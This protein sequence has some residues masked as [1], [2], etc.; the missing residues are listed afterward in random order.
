LKPLFAVPFQDTKTWQK[1]MGL[2]DHPHFQVTN[3]DVFGM[4]VIRRRLQVFEVGACLLY[5]SSE[6]MLDDF[7]KHFLPE[8]PLQ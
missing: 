3:E 7:N 8:E 5:N 4:R 6:K 1:S 2:T